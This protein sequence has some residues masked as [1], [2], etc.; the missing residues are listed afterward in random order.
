MSEERDIGVYLE[1]ILES[2][3]RI[4]KY[5]REAE[6]KDD[7]QVQDAVIRRLEIIGEAV[8]KIPDEFKKKHTLIPW[9][10]IAGMRDVL[11]HEYFTVDMERV[12]N[13]VGRDFPEFKTEIAKLLKD[14]QSSLE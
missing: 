5:V 6:S 7:G 12:W 9:K 11:I 3:Q 4:E 10:Q 14:F 1:D 13:T 2:I 8:K